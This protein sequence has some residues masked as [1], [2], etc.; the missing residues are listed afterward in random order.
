MICLGKSFL[1]WNCALQMNRLAMAI[2][3][4]VYDCRF[5]RY[6]MPLFQSDFPAT[7]WLRLTLV[8]P[9]RIMRTKMDLFYVMAAFCVLNWL[10]SLSPHLNMTC[11]S[12]FLFASRIL[13][14]ANFKRQSA[15]LIKLSQRNDDFH[16]FDS[17]FNAQLN[18]TKV[19]RK[20]YRNCELY[21]NYNKQ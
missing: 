21:R 9:N 15:S 16:V 4:S 7:S 18:K 14:I 6:C 11:A 3:M 19:I 1:A 8:F 2:W 10:C 12:I 17:P 5:G 13:C 20:R